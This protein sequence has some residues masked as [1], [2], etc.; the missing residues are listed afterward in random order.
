MEAGAFAELVVPRFEAVCCGLVFDDGVDACSDRVHLAVVGEL[1]LCGDGREV[2]VGGARLGAGEEVADDVGP[3]V[4]HKI[5]VLIATVH[6]D[7]EIVHAILLPAGLEGSLPFG[8]GG[9]VASDVDGGGRALEDVELFRAGAEMGNDLHGSGS[10]AYDADYF[11]LEF[12]EATRWP[13]T[14]VFVVPT[15]GVEGVTLVGFDAVEARHFGSMEWSGGRD[16]EAG[17]DVVFAGSLDCPRSGRVVPTKGLYLCLKE[18]LV[19]QAE[20]LADGFCVLEEFVGTRILLYWYVANFFEK[21][22]VDVR[23]DVTLSSRISVPV[24]GKVSKV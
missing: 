4:A 10:C 20:F 17:F 14:G 19:V 5:L 7:V 6:Q 24:P 11:V 2:G 18:G 1:H 8:I 16:D 12:I 23:F 13:T 3:A 9:A 22:H 21:R 15:R